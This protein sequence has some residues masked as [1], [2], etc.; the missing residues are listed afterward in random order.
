MTIIDDPQFTALLAQVCDDQRLVR[1][2][3]R[4]IDYGPTFGFQIDLRNSR[5]R[6]A[7]IAWCPALRDTAC[8]LT[9][10]D[11]DRVDVA[12]LTDVVRYFLEA[13]G[14]WSVEAEG[15]AAIFREI[16]RLASAVRKQDWPAARH[17]WDRLA[18]HHAR[19]IA[20]DP[21]LARVGAFFANEEAMVRSAE[22]Q[23][24]SIH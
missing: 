2:R 10:L 8:V 16:E 17:A 13:H 5:A 21:L 3:V 24:G 15:H 23:S 19:L 7:S 6:V 4:V 11:P 18:P 12:R 9:G 1:L 20:N 14:Y 22:R